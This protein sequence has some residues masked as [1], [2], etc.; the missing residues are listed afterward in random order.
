MNNKLLSGF[1][2]HLILFSLILLPGVLPF[3]SAVAQEVIPVPEFSHTRG[4][5]T[6]PFD[7]TL[8]VPDGHA[9]FYTLN[10]DDPTTASIPYDGPVTISGRTGDPNSYSMISGVSYEYATWAPPVGEVFK[11]NVFRAAVFLGD[12][13][14]GPVYTHTYFVDPGMPERYSLPVVSLVTDSLNFFDYDTGI[15][16]LGRIHDEF[17]AANPGFQ[18]MFN[19]G[20][21]AN[22]G[23][24]GD[25]WERPVHV[26]LFEPDGTAVIAQDAGVRIH[27]GWSR[28]FRQKSLRLYSRS[29][30][31][32]S[33]FRY[34]IF[35]DQTLDN[36]NRLLLRNSGQD[37][38]QTMLRDAF[39]QSLARNL[40]F[41]TMAYRPS[42]VFLNG[43]F[44]GVYNIRERY[45]V[46]YLE[47][48]YGVDPL[49][50]DILTGN[51]QEKEGSRQHYLDMINYI[52][53]N[54]LADQEHYDY[55]RTQMD[56][57]NFRDYY[58]T[59]IY[60][61]NTDWPHNN[62][63]FWRKQTTAYE[64]DA[65]Y[66]HDGRW[67]WMMFDT[68][69]GFGW[70]NPANAY[71]YNLLEVAT[72]PTGSR[73]NNPWS[74]FLIYSLLQNEAFRTGFYTRMADLLNTNFSPSRVRAKLEQ[75]K[76]VI[77][78][79][80][81]EH[82]DRWGYHDDRWK[83]PQ[84][85]GDWET[86][87]D[88]MRHFAQNRAANVRVH[89]K[90]KFSLGLLRELTVDVDT[91][92]SG[93]I[94][95]NTITID[96]NTPGVTGY[97][98]PWSGI[99][100]SGMQ[101]QVIARPAPGYRFAGWSGSYTSESDTLRFSF[102][103]KSTLTANF[104]PDDTWAGNPE[105]P[106][107]HRLS[108]N[109]Y[110][111]RSWSSDHPDSTFPRNMVFLQSDID[112]PLL[113]DE[114]SF[115][116]HIPHDDYNADDLATVGFPYNNTRRTR[117]NGLDDGGLSFINTGRGRDL[118]AAVLAL[119]TRGTT[120]ID[121]KWVGG[122]LQA[123]SRTYNIRLQYR[124]GTGGVWKDVT[125]PGGEPVEYVRSGVA[126]H[127]LT[128][129]PDRLPA[130]VDDQAYV[131]L[132]WKYYFTGTR[133]SE[134]SGARDMLRLDEIEVTA[135]TGS[136]TGE[137]AQNDLPGAYSLETNYPNPFNPG[138]MIRYSLPEAGSV[139][140]VVYNILG[141]EISVLT[142]GFR[143]AGRHTAWF[144]GTGLAS[145]VYIYRLEAGGR[146]MTGKMMLVR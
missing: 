42:V 38:T 104:E 85:I 81:Q 29:D 116:Y 92:G 122:T 70:N 123:N 20:A 65:P 102:P 95:V 115:L 50:V 66:G 62:I 75:T 13:Q 43:E 67:R 12:V 88:L 54:G 101:M 26:E 37:W 90:N 41:E 68:D 23:Q 135:S 127:S 64:P 112:D 96:E 99:Y 27:G 17:R 82:F 145:G 56:V 16:V 53:A 131:Q 117:I 108:S 11:T 97:P 39:M 33:R 134:T 55:I 77:E 128:I 76:S 144:D 24:R 31:G 110:T 46:F 52:A 140:L 129:G 63:D 103:G 32:T 72:D 1:R 141:R 86:R 93:T 35:Q 100:Y 125:G 130:E 119:D 94:Q 22:Y 146:S 18:P 2:L 84:T 30:Y 5:F 60:I 7:L 132:R 91:P 49:Q 36:Y 87:L 71:Q 121:V 143:D 45:D 139:R 83:T 78:P 3:P 137:P 44:W 118:G 120:G 136:S 47:T 9:V 4:Y 124:I 113:E 80:M 114:V 142:E 69:F 61:N 105:N 21:P 40:S 34:R 51:R 126:G 58:L 57:E 25:E 138:T 98:Y 19:G 28:A 8:T 15:Y 79:H 6:T 133:L 59:N 73:G 107:P 109:W 14:V 111:F 10:G 106:F 74:T 48:H 89:V